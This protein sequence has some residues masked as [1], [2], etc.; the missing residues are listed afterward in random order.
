MSGDEADGM[1][2]TICPCDFTRAGQ[3]VDDTLNARLV[4]PICKGCVLHCVIDACHS[5]TALDLPYFTRKVPGQQQLE[6]RAEAK[7]RCALAMLLTVQ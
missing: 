4:R 2:E 1:N 5:G 3:I 6:W 7:T